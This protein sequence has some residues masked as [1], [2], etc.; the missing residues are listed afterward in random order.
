MP[1]KFVGQPLPRIDAVEKVRG[2]AIF[3]ADVNLPHMLVAKFLPSPH[4]HAEILSIDTSIAEALPGV[5]AV[6]T[7]ADIPETAVHNPTS[8]LHAFLARQFIVFAGQAVAAVA[9]EDSTTAEAAIE[10]IDVKYRPLPVVN[11][12]HQAIQPDCVA[13]MH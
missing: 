12:L 1:E 10:L 11:T 13:V 8:R 3:G 4:A 2:E 6:V 7:A 9:A 5:Q